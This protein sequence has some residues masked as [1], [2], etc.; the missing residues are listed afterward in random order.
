MRRAI[1]AASA[2]DAGGRRVRATADGPS[3]LVE[4]PEF[5]SNPGQLCSYVHRPAELPDRP[6]LVVCLHGCTQ[7]AA[8]YDLGSGWSAL[9]DR[10]GFIALFPEQQSRNN[11]NTC[12]TW[13]GDDDTRRDSGEALSIRQMI[14]TVIAVH[15]V[16]PSKVFITGLSAGGAMASSMLAAY[17]DV[18]S[19][20]AIVA[21]LPAGSASGVSEALAAMARG[22]SHSQRQWG[23]LAR[24]ASAHN[25]PRPRISVWHGTG[26]SVVSPV[27][28]EACMLQA[29]DLH[30]LVLVPSV[31]ETSGAYRRRVWRNDQERAVVEVHTIEGMGHGVALATEGDERCGQP[32]SYQFDVGISSPIRILEFFGITD[33]AQFK[34]TPTEASKQSEQQKP[35]PAPEVKNARSSVFEV[36]RDSGV[37]NSTATGRRRFPPLSQEL[38][39]IIDAAM[40]LGRPPKK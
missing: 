18:F 26:D 2:N 33:G 35:G 38:H 13:F 19:A 20:G 27:N 10:Y 36:L 11:P 4:M 25:G 24:A 8:S 37:L 9:A 23:D 5:G 17:P 31:D 7:T 1:D 22:R 21:G 30:G 40:R 3:V 28:A 12:F 29:V 14:D 16:D 34:A 6:A 15:D 32:G 39:R